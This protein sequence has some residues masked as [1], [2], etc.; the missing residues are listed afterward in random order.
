MASGAIER[1]GV[2]GGVNVGTAVA[3]GSGAVAVGAAPTGA[4]KR[5]ISGSAT[6]T[7]SGS[8]N[9]KSDKTTAAIPSPIRV[10]TIPKPNHFQ[11]TGSRTF[12]PPGRF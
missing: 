4:V 2:G 8:R 10:I 6:D 1:S 12:E 11:G 3:V 7:G 9:R 5:M